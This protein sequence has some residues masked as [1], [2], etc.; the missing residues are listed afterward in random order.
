MAAAQAPDWRA[1][2]GDWRALVVLAVAVLLP[3]GRTSELPI[4]IGAAGSVVLLWRGRGTLRGNTGVRLALALFACYWL[5]ALVSAPDA[6]SPDKTWSTVAVTLRFLPF[7]L[8]A[9][10]ALRSDG[11]WRGLA[12]AIAVV[13]LVW[14]IDAWVQFATG[15][16]LGGPAES[17]RL[18]GVFGA[19]NLKFGP[20]LATMSPFLLRAAR[21]HVGRRGLAVAYALLLV[22]VLLAGSRAAWIAFAVVTLVVAWRETR[23]WL[24]FL[25]VVAL[26]GLCCA[27]VVAMVW[28]DSQRFD[29]RVERSLLALDGSLAGVDAAASGRLAIWRDAWAMSRAHPLNGVGVR[30]FRYAYPAYADP[31]DPFVDAAGDRGAAHAHQIVLEVSTET[32]AIGLLLW[33]AGVAFAID[34]WR[35][36]SPGARERAAAP[37]LALAA[38]CFPLDTHLAFY[39][40]WWGLLFWWL[41]ALYCAALGG[42]PESVASGPS[43]GRVLN[44]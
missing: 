36:A 33:L 6:V 9:V 21:R 34:A 14:A 8:F 35:R 12:D 17:E 25:G 2:A 1:L 32:G 38:M 43:Q 5:P 23:R 37:A 30:G 39:S 44:R 41:L 28:H 4:L 29:A 20:V 24:P 15:F 11:V 31:R 40:A 22:P 16:S 3:V 26:G 19:D 13:V 10:L 7:A 27:L 42:A 18:S